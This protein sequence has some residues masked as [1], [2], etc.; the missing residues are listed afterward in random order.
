MGRVVARV[1]RGCQGDCYLR[2]ANERLRLTAVRSRQRHE[3]G[4]ALVKGSAVFAS[5]VQF[6]SFGSSAVRG[7]LGM[8]PARMTEASAPLGRVV[9][10]ERKPNT[11]HEFHFWT[12]VDSPVGIG[13]IVRVE[14][15]HPV[16]GH[17]PRV[18][19]VVVEGFSFTDL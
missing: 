17:I 4:E 8:G 15:T 18:Y 3:Y 2:A 9:A 10:T 19:G 6:G 1:E 16:E 5:F 12:A 14:G 13:T 7:R 11:P